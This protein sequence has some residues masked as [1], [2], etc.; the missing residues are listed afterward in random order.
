VKA[1][2][3]ANDMSSIL[4]PAGCVDIMPMTS[5]WRQFIFEFNMSTPIFRNSGQLWAKIGICWETFMQNEF[6]VISSTVDYLCAD[7]LNIREQYN[8]L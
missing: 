8:A 5:I 6:H 4:W 7:L 1:W 3:S 2:I